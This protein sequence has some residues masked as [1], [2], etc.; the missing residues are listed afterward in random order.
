MKGLGCQVTRECLQGLRGEFLPS[1]TNMNTRR[2]EKGGW[3]WGKEG[4]E[5]REKEH[6]VRKAMKSDGV[7][8]RGIQRYDKGSLH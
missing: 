8:S 7:L 4:R 6:K 2:G 1:F 3:G 5:T